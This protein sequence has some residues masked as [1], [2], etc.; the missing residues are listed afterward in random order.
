MWDKVVLPNQS[1]VQWM[2]ANNSNHITTIRILTMTQTINITKL[3]RFS[4]LPIHHKFN[5]TKVINLNN[6]KLCFK[7]HNNP[8]LSHSLIQKTCKRSRDKYSLNR[9]SEPSNT[10]TMLNSNSNNMQVH[11][12]CNHKNYNKLILLLTIKLALISRQ[13]E[14]RQHR[15]LYKLKLLC[16]SIIKTKWT[17]ILMEVHTYSS[18]QV[19]NSNRI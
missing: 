7:L 16:K 10:I 15:L 4:K 1:L 18:H 12:K 8:N 3:L 9:F 11:I 14:V 17:S 2:L 6:N 13:Q 19:I 5:I